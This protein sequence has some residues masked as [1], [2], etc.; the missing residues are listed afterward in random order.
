SRRTQGRF[1]TRPSGD[2]KTTKIA[3]VAARPQPSPNGPGFAL[4]VRL[5]LNLG[6]IAAFGGLPE[7]M[8]GRD[9]SKL[10]R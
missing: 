4:F 2:T 3:K 10:A 7:L 5:V 6:T 8:L 1:A 9:V